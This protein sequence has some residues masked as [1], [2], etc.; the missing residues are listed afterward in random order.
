VTVQVVVHERRPLRLRPLNT[1]PGRAPSPDRHSISVTS[2]PIAAIVGR[3]VISAYTASGGAAMVTEARAV[4]GS[5]RVMTRCYRADQ[6]SRGG[7][8]TLI[9]R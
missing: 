9:L 4:A 5:A 1:A 8:R 3:S 6:E 2:S 7:P